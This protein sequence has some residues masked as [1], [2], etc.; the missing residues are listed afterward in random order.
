[1]R[2][3]HIDRVNECFMF[4]ARKGERKAKK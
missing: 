1:M 4:Q 3:R 2:G